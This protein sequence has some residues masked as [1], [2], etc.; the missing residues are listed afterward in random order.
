[1]MQLITPAPRRLWTP[2]RAAIIKRLPAPEGHPERRDASFLPGMFPAMPASSMGPPI[3]QFSTGEKSRTFGAWGFERELVT[4]G[5]TQAGGAYYHTTSG[6][7]DWWY[8][9]IYYAHDANHYGDLY[10]Y[11]ANPTLTRAGPYNRLCFQNAYNATKTLGNGLWSY[12]VQTDFFGSATYNW[13]FASFIATSAPD[14][15]DTTADCAFLGDG[16]SNWGL[17][18]TNHDTGYP[19]MRG[20]MYDTGYKYTDPIYVRLN[21]PLVAF[22]GWP[23]P[24][25]PGGIILKINSATTPVTDAAYENSDINTHGFG[26]GTYNCGGFAPG[27]VFE[28]IAGAAPSANPENFPSDTTIEKTMR[29]MLAWLGGNWDGDAKYN[30]HLS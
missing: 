18:I 7:V 3:D 6:A 28:M 1:M 20:F 8:D 29:N 19:Y 14:S 24:V 16:N 4:G 15:A 5:L 13:V 2:P 27:Y 12:T 22:V 23:T 25:T 9:Q 17:W 26:T 21:V 10:G 30:A 11:P